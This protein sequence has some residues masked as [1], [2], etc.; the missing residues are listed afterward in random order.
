MTNL[1]YLSDSCQSR[2]GAVISRS[3]TGRRSFITLKCPKDHVFANVKFRLADNSVNTNYNKCLVNSLV[4][5]KMCRWRRRCKINTKVKTL[6]CSASAIQLSNLKCVPE[7][8][9]F[10]WMSES[11]RLHEIWSKNISA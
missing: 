6:N 2:H 1:V 5:Q 11:F 7:G 8:Q 4:A 9:L 10:T 3:V